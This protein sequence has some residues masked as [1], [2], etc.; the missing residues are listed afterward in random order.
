MSASDTIALQNLILKQLRQQLPAPPPLAGDTPF[1][2]LGIDSIGV[3]IL[4][5]ELES[6]LD[7]IFAPEDLDMA[8]FTDAATLAALLS[9]KYH[10]TETAHD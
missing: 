8:N 6:A 1:S 4:V 7:F 10:L 5:A 2:A 3:V 9:E